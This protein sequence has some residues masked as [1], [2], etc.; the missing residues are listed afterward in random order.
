MA[1]KKFDDRVWGTHL[2]QL[3]NEH[4]AA[5][6]IAGGHAG[7]DPKCTNAEAKLVA[8]IRRRIRGEPAEKHFAKQPGGP[9]GVIK[10]IT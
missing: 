9:P 4:S 7:C 6:M 5:H 3:L 10:G 8:E 1:K 2:G